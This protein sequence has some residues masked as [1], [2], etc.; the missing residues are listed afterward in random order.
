LHRHAV[1]NVLFRRVA[2]AGG[3]IAIRRN[4]LRLANAAVTFTGNSLDEKL[5]QNLLCECLYEIL[6]KPPHEENTEEQEERL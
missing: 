6:S 2:T 1:V 5:E 4:E 3:G